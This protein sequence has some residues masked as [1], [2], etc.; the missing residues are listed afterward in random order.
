MQM[1]SVQYDLWLDDQH[2]FIKGTV[3]VPPHGS[4]IES[5]FWSAA[6]V[7]QSLRSRSLTTIS[8]VSEWTN[9]V[10]FDGSDVTPVMQDDATTRR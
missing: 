3:L 9:S 10:F 4:R 5:S 8:R 6:M 2:A 1:R 7:A